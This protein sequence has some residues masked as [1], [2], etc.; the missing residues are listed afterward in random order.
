MNDDFDFMVNP[1]VFNISLKLISEG[2]ECCIDK[3]YGSSSI[4]KNNTDYHNNHNYDV[5]FI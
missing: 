4:I 2:D 5:G 1:L 3:I